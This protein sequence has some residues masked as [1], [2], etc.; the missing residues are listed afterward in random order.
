MS[1]QANS[2]SVTSVIFIVV[3]PRASG[4]DH[5][6]LGTAAHQP[7]FIDYMRI[8]VYKG[9][10]ASRIAAGVRPPA[11]QGRLLQGPRPSHPDPAPRGPARPRAERP[12]APDRKSTRL[13]SSH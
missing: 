12:G 5:T 1:L 11:L 7:P 9:I 8:S 10:V 4:P 13:N 3:P 6:T 2:V